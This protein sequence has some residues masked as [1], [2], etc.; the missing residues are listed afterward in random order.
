ML[1]EERSE[2]F[3]F[4]EW[5]VEHGGGCGCWCDGGGG[6]DEPVGTIDDEGGG[7]GGGG[8]IDKP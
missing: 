8:L 4:V 2:E 3:G 6:G 7:G 1:N 5:S